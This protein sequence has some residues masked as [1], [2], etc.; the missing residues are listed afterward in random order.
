MKFIQNPSFH[1]LI[2]ILL[3]L[4]QLIRLINFI[5]VYGGLEHDSGWALGTSRSLAETGRYAA[6]ASTIADLTP[7]GTPNI[8][9]RYNVQ[10]EDG[11]VYFA[12][13]SIGA[14]SIVPN[15]III[16]LFGPGFWQYR[17]GP[18]LFLFV[19]LLSASFLLYQ[20]GGLLSIIITN[21][22]L[23]F[24]PSSACTLYDQLC[25]FYLFL[26]SLIVFY[27]C[28]LCVQLRV[29]FLILHILSLI[30]PQTFPK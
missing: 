18:L 28:I 16:K 6:M 17:F 11:R 3:T 10:D 30:L 27:A 2:I 22:F 20:V 21:L 12:P 23:F 25:F 13:D 24:Y 8:Y 26:Q 9:G 14:G 29:S 1:W 5:T 15:A 4:C 7:G 19:A